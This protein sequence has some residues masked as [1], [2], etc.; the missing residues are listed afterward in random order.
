MLFIH[1]M[2]LNFQR[3]MIYHMK[4]LLQLMQQLQLKHLDTSKAQINVVHGNLIL[5]QKDIFFQSRGEF[6]ITIKNI[7]IILIKLF[8]RENFL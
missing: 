8:R 1:L 7:E 2:V 5:L 6:I 4:N 3:Q